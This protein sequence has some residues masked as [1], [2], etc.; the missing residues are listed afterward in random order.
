VFEA[1]DLAF[2]AVSANRAVANETFASGGQFP[3]NFKYV[4]FGADGTP[5]QGEYIDF[6]LPAVPAGT[7]TLSMRYK[8]HPA[9][10]GILQ[11]AVDGQPVGMPLNQH[12]SP[13]TF[14]ETNFGRV[15][16]ASQS[17]HIIRLTVTGRDATA[18]AYTITADVFTLQPDNNAPLVNAPSS[19]TLE[20]A[21]PQ[22]TR[23]E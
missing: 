11:L 5:P 7:Y 15:Q 10:R 18:S 8:S 23:T 20:A 9:N 16:F 22:T 19:M 17:D 3:S 2:T 6:V 4:S 14:L 21:G 1:E 13:A 12:S